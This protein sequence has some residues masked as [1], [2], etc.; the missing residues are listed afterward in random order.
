LMRDD[1]IRT[2][3][4]LAAVIDELGR[5]FPAAQIARAFH[6]TMAEVVARMAADARGRTGLNIVA[7]SGGCFQN[8]LLLGAS[9]RRLEEDRFEVLVHRRVP[10][11]DGGLSLGQAVI[12]AAQLKAEESGGSLCASESRAE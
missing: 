7:L 8:R 12:A 3:E 11:N 5:G 10:A 4:I 9:I 6:D 1:V 2:D